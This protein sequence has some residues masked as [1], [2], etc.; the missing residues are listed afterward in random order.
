[1]T[2]LIIDATATTADGRIATASVVVEVNAAAFAA[3]VT[4]SA[5][6][7]QQADLM[8]GTPEA[9][10]AGAEKPRAEEEQRILGQAPHGHLGGETAPLPGQ[11]ISPTN[12]NDVETARRIWS[13][14]ASR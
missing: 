11:T 13:G 9:P 8:I 14:W 7:T 12:R 3:E 10:P 1:M 2:Q 4:D 5:G 6:N